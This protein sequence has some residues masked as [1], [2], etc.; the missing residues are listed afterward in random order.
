MSTVATANRLVVS[1][2]ADLSTWGRDQ[3]D[4]RHFRAWLKR[5]H[6][7][8]E[9]GDIWE[10]FLDVGCCGSALEVPLRVERVVGGDAV[11]EPTHINYEERAAC[12]L[13]DGWAV[14]SEAGP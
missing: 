11:G 1:Y 7:E 3:L 6:P 12:G 5:A 14:Q 4:T 10:E 8:P 2:P 13:A 9:A